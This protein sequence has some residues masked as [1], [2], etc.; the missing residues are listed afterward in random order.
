[1]CN[2]NNADFN[3]DELWMLTSMTLA[4]MR[5]AVEQWKMV[6][7]TGTGTVRLVFA[8]VIRAA[9]T[10][11]ITP[12]VDP[13]ILTAMMFDEIKTHPGE[14]MYESM[15]LK[16]K[17]WRHMYSVVTSKLYWR[18]H[19]IKSEA[20]IINTTISRHGLA[21][22]YGF[23]RAGIMLVMCISTSRSAGVDSSP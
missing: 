21:S 10:N 16:T 11:G 17:S 18:S 2:L 19:V 23:T 3:G 4:R 13:A 7:C 22:T 14:G 1:M 12:E 20:E 15:M 9:R 8:D 6:W 5:E